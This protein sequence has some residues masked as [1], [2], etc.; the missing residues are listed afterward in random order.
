MSE[1]LT[2]KLPL[3]A[4]DKLNL[5]LTTVQNLERRSITAETQFGTVEERLK[6]LEFGFNNFSSRLQRVEQKV[7]QRLYDTRPMWHRV[8][9][10]IGELHKSQQRLEKGQD[11]L[12]DAIRKITS[13]IHAIGVR[14]GRLE[15]NRNRRNSST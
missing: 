7:E 11:V 6:R 4:N 8:V 12:N 1:D 3:D 2:K 10:D 15:G 13:D 14:L 9:D 5:I